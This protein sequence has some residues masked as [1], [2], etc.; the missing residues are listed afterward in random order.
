MATIFFYLR[1]GPNGP[2]KPQQPESFFAACGRN[3]ILA[4]WLFG[5][6]AFWLFGFLAFWLFGFCAR[7]APY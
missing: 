6:L 4:F 2:G 1:A 7:S 5:F 3:N